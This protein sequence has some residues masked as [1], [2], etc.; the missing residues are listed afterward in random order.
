MAAAFSASEEN[1]VIL[2]EQNEKLGKKLYITGKGRCNLTNAADTE[3][4]LQQVV[5]NRRFLYSALYSFTNT[6]LMTLMEE[7][8][9]KLK[10]ERGGRVFPAS[11]HSSDVIRTWERMLKERQ[12]DIRLNTR[13][14]EILTENGAVCGVR[15][16]KNGREEILRCD[17]LI[18]ATGGLSYSSTGATGDGYRFSSALGHR[19]TECRPALNP[20]CVKEAF[21]AEMSGLSLRNAGI[22]ISGKKGLYYEDFGELM[23]THF[24]VSGPVILSASSVIGKYFDEE[25]ELTLSI[26]LKP[27][28]TEEMLDARILRDFSENINKKF[29]NALG[30]LLPSGM[31]GTVIEKSGIDP[32]KSVH[33]ITRGER[34]QL[35]LVI[36]NF[37]MTLTGLHGFDDAVITQGGVDVREINA[38]TMESKLVRN[39]Y[40][41]G[42]LIDVD[43]MTGG[44]NLQIAWST[45]ILAGRSIKNSEV[46]DGN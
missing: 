26:D 6:D 41:A 31:I 3:T 24:G 37:D 32:E 5:T 46:S 12:V 11:D 2:L 36:K 22:R 19:V 17:A 45:G 20:L 34:R 18:L 43:A 10:T 4:Q 44:F 29:R 15:T 38:S 33:L 1:H 40:F 9:L 35:L 27:A 30:K 39:L 7:H 25:A 8:G 42:E 21:A 14:T 28:L 13:V 16:V 23:F